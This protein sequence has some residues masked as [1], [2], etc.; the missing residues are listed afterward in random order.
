[1]RYLDDYFDPQT[2]SYATE[3]VTIRKEVKCSGARRDKVAASRL[4]CG[5]PKA[6]L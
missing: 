3:C 6:A 4:A 1:L 5:K 2:L